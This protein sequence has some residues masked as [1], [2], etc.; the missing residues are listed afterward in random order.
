MG[1]GFLKTKTKPEKEDER[2]QERLGAGL[3]ITAVPAMFEAALA[4]EISYGQN[5]PLCGYCSY[6]TIDTGID[7]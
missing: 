3:S 1:L 5:V 2:K 7:S 6:S 4:G